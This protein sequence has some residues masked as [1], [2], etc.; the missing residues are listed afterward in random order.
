MYLPKRRPMVFA[1]PNVALGASRDRSRAVRLFIYYSSTLA[2]PVPRTSP[3]NQLRANYGLITNYSVLRISGAPVS[4]G[5]HR[6]LCPSSIYST[7]GRRGAARSR[8]RSS[9]RGPDSLRSTKC[10][11]HERSRDGDDVF[12]RKNPLAPNTFQQTQQARRTNL[13]ARACTIRFGGGGEEF[14]SRWHYRSQISDS[15]T[16]PLSSVLTLKLTKNHFVCVCVRVFG[17]SSLLMFASLLFERGRCRRRRRRKSNSVCI[18]LEKCFYSVH[19]GFLS[20]KKKNVPVQT[21]VCFRGN[22]LVSSAVRKS[23]N[24][25]EYSERFTL[26]F[27]YTFRCSYFIRSLFLQQFR[28]R[29]N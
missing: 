26:F 17:I 4:G 20:E 3:E 10:Q 15:I 9:G 22:M 14:V 6:G 5:P 28:K 1:G 23:A 24:L 25:K 11:K 8:G 18:P 29:V 2:C 7:A 27:V 12:P 13:C 19:G 21:A 16:T